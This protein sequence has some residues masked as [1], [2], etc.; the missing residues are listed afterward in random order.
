MAEALDQ[1]YFKKL[2][3]KKFPKLDKRESS[4]ST[5][6]NKYQVITELAS[7][8]MFMGAICSFPSQSR[9]VVSLLVYSSLPHLP[10][11]LL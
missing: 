1:H 7:L 3:L 11:T 6:W 5:F 8:V 9:R 4:E 10:M 2:A